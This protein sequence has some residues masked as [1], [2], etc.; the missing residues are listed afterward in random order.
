MLKK[1]RAIILLLGL[2]AMGSCSTK[3]NTAYSRWW[4]AFNTRYNVYFNGITHYDE[5]LKQM[6]EKYEDDYSQRLFIHPAEAHAEEKATKPSGNFDRTIEKMQKAIALHSIKK[7]PKRKAGRRSEKEKEWLKRE[8]YNPFLHNAWFTLARAQYMNGDFLSSA[9]TFHYITRHFKWLPDLVLECQIWEALS[10]CAMNWTTEADNVLVHIH[11]E[12]IEKPK[13]LALYN[14]AMADY[15]L[16]SKNSAEAAKYLAEA[17]RGQKG[18][19]KVRQYFLLGQLYADVGNKE[20]AYQAFGKAGSSNGTTYRTKFNARIKQ[21]AVFSGKDI[22]G[23]VRALKR[24]TRFDRNKDYLD[25]IYYAIGNLYLS[26]KDTTSAVANYVKANEKSTRNGIDKAINNITLGGIYFDQHKYDLAQPCYSE[27]I[28]QLKEDYPNY[29]ALKKRSDVLDELAVYAQNVTLQDSLLRLSSMTEEEQLKVVEKIIKELKKKEK[30]AEEEAR[31]QEYDAKS[32]AMGNQLNNKGNLPNSFQMNND[33][34]WYF[35]NT[36]PKNAGKT[37]FQKI[38]GNRKL[39]DNWRRRNKNTFSLG[40]DDELGDSIAALNDSIAGASDTTS[41]S[42]EEMERSQDPHYPE[43][44]L[45]QIPKTEEERQ[46]SHTIIQEGLFNM[47][48]IL[49]DHLEDYPSSIGEFSKLLNRYPDNIY[50]LDVYYNMYLMYMRLNNLELAEHYRLLITTEFAESGYGKAMTD[51]NYLENLKM[52]HENQ[53]EMYALAYDAYMGNR[54]LDVHDSYEEMMRRYPLSDLMP[55]F[56]FIDALTYVT[57]KNYDKFKSTLKEMLER[58]PETDLTPLA[59]SIMKQL[60]QGRKPHGGS[61]GTIRGMLWETRLSNDS[62]MLGADHKLSDFVDDPSKPHYYVFAY[63]T[64]S[65]SANA[66]LYTVARHNFTK[67][68]TADFDLEQMTF[69]RIGLLVVKGF[70][71]YD[72]LL[73]YRKVLDEDTEMEIPGKVREVM[74]SEDN[75][76]ILINEGRSLEEYF[77]FLEHRNDDQVEAPIETEIDNLDGTVPP[78]TPGEEE[79][80]GEEEPEPDEPPAEPEK[81]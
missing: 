19:Q 74:I 47:G 72:D 49:K 28:P 73:H 57:E 30:E 22:S 77:M 68:V 76:K 41:M 6:E 65:V 55:K 5:Q 45:K 51:V 12:K 60:N 8:E 62:T 3:K 35:Y 27:A 67:F 31:R 46:N 40:D 53:E 54:N 11:P 58:Y 34:S 71:N 80:Q 56:M 48:L 21:S 61:G 43:Y 14:M 37:E 63:P 20:K 17:V 66:L 15:H 69:G 39:E 70:A 59:S 33:K 10:Y 1:A 2:L 36:T 9:A 4:Q 42:K 26:R 52:M 29:K 78:D 13:I 38:W 24:M 23:E 50:R 75:F 44:Y 18:A 32:G 64:D 16:K 81:P 7:K 25:Q 79:A